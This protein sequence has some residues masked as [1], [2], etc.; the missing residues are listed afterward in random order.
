MVTK[1]SLKA[2][3]QTPTMCGVSNF[4]YVHLMQ[5]LTLDETLLSK[6]AFEK[7]CDRAGRTVKH[8]QADNGRFADKAFLDDCNK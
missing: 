1:S 4:V 3:G 5:D 2:T 6:V 8:Y 7:I